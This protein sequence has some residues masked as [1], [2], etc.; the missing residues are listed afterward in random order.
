MKFSEYTITE[1]PESSVDPLGFTQTFS[2]LRSRLFPQFTVL[3]NAPTY[4]GVLA[5]IYQIQQERKSKKESFSIA[6]RKAECLWGLATASA[7][8]S[9]LNVTKYQAIL[10]GRDS[11]SLKNIGPTNA[12]FRSLGYG[13]LGHYSNPSIAWGFLKRG[14]ISLTPLGEEL[15]GSVAK[16]GNQM[17]LEQIKN[18]L[19]GD[20]ILLTDL[21]DLGKAYELDAAPNKDEKKIWQ[22]ALTDIVIRKP[23]IS[24]L[25]ADIPNEIELDELRKDEVSYKDFFPQ[26]AKRFPKLKTTFRLIHYFEIISAICAFIFEREYLLCSDDEQQRPSEAGELEEQLAN[27][28]TK[29][30]SDYLAS[31]GQDTRGLFAELK[32]ASNYQSTADILLTHHVKHQKA[33][34]T[35]P[36]MENGKLRVRDRF[37][38]QK[39]TSLH[40]ELNETSD[41]K[42]LAL[43]QY[44]YQRNWHFDRAARYNRY[45][46]DEV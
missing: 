1:Q 33:K 8:K 19:D 4:H 46:K 17:L 16:R 3:S 41:E 29:C 43:L 18:W 13:T 40:E 21:T 34:G 25:W 10:E 27:A 14:G 24:D 28:L 15:A 26:M 12:V 31:D 45:I 37:D 30:S 44:R 36:Y 6:F 22:A 11:I 5:L 23:E 2:A 32:R 38:R 35:L 39:F 20:T 42:R 7:G 9:I